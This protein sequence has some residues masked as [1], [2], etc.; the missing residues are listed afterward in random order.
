MET[1]D[2]CGCSVHSHL[3]KIANVHYWNHR[4]S[5]WCQREVLRGF[6]PHPFRCFAREQEAPLELRS[7]LPGKQLS[8]PVC[9]AELFPHLAVSAFVLLCES[10]LRLFRS[11]VG[12]SSP[13][14][15]LQKVVSLQMTEATEH[16][17]SAF[18][19]LDVWMDEWT[20]EG[21]AANVRCSAH[22][23]L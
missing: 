7:L 21:V 14:W 22:D 5:W 16:S 10:E 20:V 15:A 17:C 19:P 13:R 1:F 4:R 2:N 11:E 3:C 6:N 8:R 9:S 23:K 18:T 12:R